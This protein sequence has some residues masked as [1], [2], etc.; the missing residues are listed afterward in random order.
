[1]KVLVADDSRIIRC[2]LNELLQ[3]WGLEVIVAKDG[4]EAWEILA[5]PDCP[6]IMILDWEMPG[7]DGLEL[8]RRISMK[9]FVRRPYTIMLT[10][11]KSASDRAMILEAGANDFIAKPFDG[12]ELQARIAV[13]KRTAALKA[14]L[15]QTLTRLQTA[16]DEKER[17]RG[18]LHK[19]LSKTQSLVSSLPSILI[20]LDIT[21]QVCLWNKAAE[22]AFGIDAGSACGR[23]LDQIPVQWSWDD[24]N[25]AIEQCCHTL[26]PV[27]MAEV[28]YRQQ[29]G[30]N[31]ILDIT[32]SPML[33]SGT[34]LGTFLL[35]SDITE[36]KNLESHLAMAQ[37]LESIGQLAAGIAHEI[38]TPMQF[39]NDNLCFVQDSFAAIE[40]VLA[41]CRTLV[42]TAQGGALASQDFEKLEGILRQADVDYLLKEIPKAL[43]QSLDG[44]ARVSKIVRAMKD[45]SHPGREEKQLIDL[46]HAIESTVT[47]ARNEWKYVAD[48]ELRLDPDLP[49][50]PC[51]AG[52]FNQVMLNLIVNAAQAIGDKVGQS[53]EQKGSITVTTE[54]VGDRVEVRVKDTGTGIPVDAQGKIFDPFFTTKEV[55]KGTGQGLAIAHDVIVKK[56]GG[57]LTFETDVGRGTTF[58]IRLPLEAKG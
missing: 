23:R 58:I 22:L 19:I 36:R 24:L 44:T 18:E 32:V 57:E 42:E 33:F 27:K 21:G 6:P 26:L 10:S 2:M 7:Y 47:V 9:E 15:N 31:G 54:K 20:E 12:A 49:L 13:A 43:S 28:G 39:V 40:S 37:K 51:R 53:H 11:K 45:F 52:E 8:C 41:V 38:N 35:A 56:H 55:G 3:A 46:N 17:A 5:Q 50:V 30:K 48:L 29:N 34:L 25:P 16:L 1:M 4:Q 14:D